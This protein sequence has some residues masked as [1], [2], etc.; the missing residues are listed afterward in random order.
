MTHFLYRPHLQMQLYKRLFEHALIKFTPTLMVDI[1]HY[2]DYIFYEIISQ[3][4]F[5]LCY[6][7]ILLNGTIC[8]SVALPIYFKVSSFRKPSNMMRTIAQEHQYDII[9]RMTHDKEETN[10]LQRNLYTYRNGSYK[11]NR[12]IKLPTDTKPNAHLWRKR[13]YR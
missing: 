6:Y 9:Y 2:W 11:G 10:D 1:T 3:R 12:C 13:N 8:S 5:S 7:D 4:G